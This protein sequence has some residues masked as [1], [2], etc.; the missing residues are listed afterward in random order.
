MTGI[1][2]SLQKINKR[3]GPLPRKGEGQKNQG[4]KEKCI[5]YTPACNSLTTNSNWCTE[6]SKAQ[7]AIP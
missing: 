5:T 6:V 1:P 3:K 2:K 4:P 7:D